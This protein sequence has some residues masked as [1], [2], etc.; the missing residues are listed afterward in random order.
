MRANRKQFIRAESH[1]GKK[2]FKGAKGVCLDLSQKSE[3]NDWSGRAD[4]FR[5]FLLGGLLKYQFVQVSLTAIEA[6]ISLSKN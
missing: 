2:Q 6:A 5:A 4:D 3:L 1:P